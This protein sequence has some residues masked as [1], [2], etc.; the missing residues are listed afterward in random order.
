MRE[1]RGK[2]VCQTLLLAQR[3]A[4]EGPRWTRAI[5]SLT[6]ALPILSFSG[7]GGEEKESA[8]VMLLCSRTPHLRR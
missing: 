3:A 1:E 5:E 8:A 6:D 4:S 2:D 7:L